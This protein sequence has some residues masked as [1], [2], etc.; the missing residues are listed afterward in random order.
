[1]TCSKQILYKELL[2]LKDVIGKKIK[3]F[4][5]IVRIKKLVI[6]IP[7]GNYILKIKENLTFSIKGLILNWIWN[8]LCSKNQRLSSK[9]LMKITKQ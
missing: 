3:D 1:M 9:T 4:S 7:E 5:G 8:M 2:I 6:G